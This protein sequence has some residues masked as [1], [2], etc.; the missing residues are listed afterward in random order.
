LRIVTALI[1]LTLAACHRQP[2]PVPQPKAQDA[3]APV[4]RLANFQKGIIKMKRMVHTPGAIKSGRRAMPGLIAKAETRYLKDAASA[5][6][7][8]AWDRVAANAMQQN[9]AALVHVWGSL[10]DKRCGR[11]GRSTRYWDAP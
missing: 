1:L 6:T 5:A 2:A 4:Q 10:A 11:Y 7:C 9:D 8:A 3:P